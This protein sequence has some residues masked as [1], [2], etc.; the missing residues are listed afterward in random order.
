MFKSRVSLCTGAAK[1]RPNRV[2]RQNS[3]IFDN[4]LLIT[5][6]MFAL[7]AAL[8]IM[9]RTASGNAP[10]APLPT[11]AAPTP[12]PQSTPRCIVVI[13]PGHGLP[14]GGATGSDTG[15]AEEGINL[16]YA[17]ALSDEL[18]R[19]GIACV[20]TRADANALAAD[21]KQD[22]ALRVQLIN[23]ASAAAVISIHMN[24]F[25]DRTIS[26][27]M[28][29]YYEGSAQGEALAKSVLD[30]VCTALGRPLRHVN[31]GDYYI[32]KNSD[33]PAIIL[34]CGFLSNPADEA[35]LPTAEHMRIMMS[36]AAE[37]ILDFLEQ[38]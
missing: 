18:S 14:D 32:I 9:F 29:F 28:A 33:P 34:E 17:L 1:R 2:F 7:L 15:I 27:P 10:A 26:G 6:A 31:P 30:S 16:D 5:A 22:M 12:A 3:T 19:L 21:K 24:K 23:S 36:A 25:S 37:G 38:G 35:L 8:L 4:A 11:P 20:L 13:D